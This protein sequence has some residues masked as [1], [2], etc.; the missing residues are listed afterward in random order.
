MIDADLALFLLA[1][2][3]IATACD[4]LFPASTT[5]SWNNTRAATQKDV[6]DV[7]RGRQ[8]GK[9]IDTT[10]LLLFGLLA[11]LLFAWLYR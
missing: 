3:G 6:A 7:L 4:R 11:F 8:T 5:R 10:G 2:A 1:I 9:P